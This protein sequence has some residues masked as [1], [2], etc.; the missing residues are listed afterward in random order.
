MASSAL[1]PKR[2]LTL[3]C[4]M[5]LTKIAVKR[6]SMKKALP[7]PKAPG[8]VDVAATCSRVSTAIQSAMAARIPP[9]NCAIQ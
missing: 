5:T 9:A 8:K 6:I 2:P 3:A 4:R 1:P 7:S